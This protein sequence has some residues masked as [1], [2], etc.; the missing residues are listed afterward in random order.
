MKKEDPHAA[1]NLGRVTETAVEQARRLGGALTP[2]EAAEFWRR[3][4]S[5]DSEDALDFWESIAS[6]E[7]IG[8]SLGIVEP[9][10]PKNK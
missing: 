6:G 4:A 7:P 9:E 8:K 1:D 10:E 5:V 3:I 2:E